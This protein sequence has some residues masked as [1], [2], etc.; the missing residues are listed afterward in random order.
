[1]QRGRSKSSVPGPALPSVEFANGG[2][3]GGEGVAE[4]KRLER[5]SESLSALTGKLRS[6]IVEK[7][8]EDRLTQAFYYSAA[9]AILLFLTASAIA[10]WFVFQEF[11]EPL[12]W[13]VLCGALLH[14]IKT[15]W[16]SKSDRW[17]EEVSN[18]GI[19]LFA[20]LLFLL[21]SLPGELYRFLTK[22]RL[23]TASESLS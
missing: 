4:A 20:G 18:R 9:N 23:P 12:F 22:V 8:Q 17:L 19:P 21:L 16:V 10:L 5:E 11:I 6:S 3:V 1:M 14:P 2:R 7:L 13:A 15:K